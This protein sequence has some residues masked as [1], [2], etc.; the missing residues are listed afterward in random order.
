MH[1][2]TPS[3]HNA[4]TSARA[5]HAEAARVAA[6]RRRRQLARRQ[7][8]GAVGYRALERHQEWFRAFA[9]FQYIY[10]TVF[11]KYVQTLIPYLQ[12]PT[13]PSS[14]VSAIVISCI[15]LIGMELEKRTAIAR[16]YEELVHAVK[17]D[18]LIDQLVKRRVLSIR[19]SSLVFSSPFSE[20][21]MH[22]LLDLLVRKETGP[23]A[24]SDGDRQPVCSRM[25]IHTVLFCIQFCAFLYYITHGTKISIIK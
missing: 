12:L 8:F 24:P 2:T 20:F 1:H 14:P 9:L 11:C 21:Q 22:T 15:R 18:M 4:G 19:E 5:V 3:A 16:H 7:L 10:S 6:L 25:R 17:P 13:R 23:D